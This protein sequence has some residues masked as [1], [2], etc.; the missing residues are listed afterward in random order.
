MLI[1]F[2]KKYWGYALALL[3]ILAGL[4]GFI[5][6]QSDP[7]LGF[8][9]KTYRFQKIPASNKSLTNI[10]KKPRFWGKTRPRPAVQV[11]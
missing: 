10:I 4:F 7:Y 11:S 9:A 8:S 3:F 6:R 1:H 2:L 5:Q